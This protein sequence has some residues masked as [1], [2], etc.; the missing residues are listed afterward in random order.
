MQP[1]EKFDQSIMS[2]FKKQKNVK[3]G[4]VFV[5][6]EIFEVKKAKIILSLQ[7]NN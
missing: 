3:F 1:L 5:K 2:F 6:Y 7:Q 4:P